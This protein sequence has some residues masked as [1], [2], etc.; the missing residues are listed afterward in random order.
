MNRKNICSVFGLS[1]WFFTGLPAVICAG[2]VGS[3]AGTASS[4]FLKI[5]VGA[6]SAAMG[7]AFAGVADDVSALYWNPAGLARL[8]NREMTFSHNIWLEDTNYEYL[9]FV[10][11]LGKYVVGAGV[12]YLNIGTMEGW[13]VNNTPTSDFSAH[14]MA[15]ALSAGRVMNDKLSLGL[16]LKFVQE[17]IEKE[18]AS[19]FAVDAGGVYKLGEDTSAALVVQNLGTGMK[20]VKESAGL[21]MNIKIGGAHRLLEKKLLLSLDFNKYTDTTFRGNLGAEYRLSEMLALRLGYNGGNDMGSGLT[22]GF[23]LKY[24]RLN[25]DYAFVPYGDLGDAHRL[26]LSY[27]FDK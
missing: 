2:A 9:G 5:G 4:A 25:F 3:N 8:E 7:E 17:G 22:G 15:V 19:A 13:D 14:S 12:S 26:S 24:S 20:F 18:S 27:R 16:T 11:P 10:Q 23:G 21:P 6:R 1:L